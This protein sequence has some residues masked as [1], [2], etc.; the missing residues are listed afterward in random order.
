MSDQSYLGSI[1]GWAPNFAPR[2]WAFCQGQTISIQ[3]NNALY[4]LLGTTYGGNGQST[5]CLPNL[6]GR[7][8]IGAGQSPGTSF[9]AL[10]ASSG[11]ESVSLTN[12]QMPAHTHV[13]VA[14]ISASLPTSTAA[15]SSATPAANLVLAAANGSDGRDTVDVKIYAP[16]PGS[17]DLALPSSATVTVQ[18]AGGNQPISIVQPFQVINYIICMNGV[19]PSRN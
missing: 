9:Y 8:P 11:S 18:A 17:V 1:S 12:A 6:Q 2:N 15:A 5:F 7:T 16:A 10:G 14:T 4:S 3:Q 13:A 19:F